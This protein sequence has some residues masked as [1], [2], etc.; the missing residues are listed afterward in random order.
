MIQ[1]PPGQ[2]NSIFN[3]NPAGITTDN[4][5]PFAGTGTKALPNASLRYV[6]QDIPTAYTQQWNLALQRQVLRNSVLAL[7]Y[8]G[9]HSIHLYSIENTN[10]AGYRRRLPRHRSDGQSGATGSTASTAT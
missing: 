3:P 1:N 7:E 6:R 10:Q 5:G 2:F 4:V 9:T 8:T